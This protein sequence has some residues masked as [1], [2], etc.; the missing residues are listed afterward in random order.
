MSMLHIERVW[1]AIVHHSGEL[2]HHRVK[3][4]YSWWYGKTGNGE[5]GISDFLLFVNHFGLSRSDEKYDERYDLDNNDIIGISDFLIF[6]DNFGKQVPQTPTP[7]TFPAA[8]TFNTF[9]NAVAEIKRLKSILT[10]NWRL[11]DEEVTAKAINHPLRAPKDQFETTDEYNARLERLSSILDQ[12]RIDRTEYYEIR[13]I[14]HQI[15]Q[16]YLTLS[17]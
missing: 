3:I 14:Q 12:F 16:L 6:V 13:S 15:V 10:E 9:D 2:C 11:I 8:D 1:E 4:Q 17:S 5:V 7:P